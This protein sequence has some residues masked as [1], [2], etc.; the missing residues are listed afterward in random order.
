MQGAIDK[1]NEAPVV[2]AKPETPPPVE[3][4][5]VIESEKHE[6]TEEEFP[7]KEESVKSDKTP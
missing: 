4:P 2:E 1:L 5:I 3:E 6:T 7:V